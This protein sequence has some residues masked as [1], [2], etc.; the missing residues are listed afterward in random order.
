MR[1]L[2][3]AT[4]RHGVPIGRSRESYSLGAFSF[5]EFLMFDNNCK[6]LI[7]S[8]LQFYFG[9]LCRAVDN[10]F[11]AKYLQEWRKCSCPLMQYAAKTKYSN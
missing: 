7:M 4:G 10:F 1:R 3:E 6:W 5:W 2:F 11:C 9:K 8:C